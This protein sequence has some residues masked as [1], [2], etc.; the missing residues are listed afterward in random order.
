MST[1]T[2]YSTQE[3]LNESGTVPSRSLDDFVIETITSL[4]H[5]NVAKIQ[6]ITQQQIDKIEGDRDAMMKDC[7][8]RLRMNE[9]EAELCVRRAIEV[10]IDGIRQD[11]TAAICRA[12]EVTTRRVRAYLS[13]GLSDTIGKP[14]PP[15]PPL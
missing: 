3:I 10:S 2:E 1:V 9:R 7:E 4:H 6:I 11:A 12:E 14:H 8:V 13:S 15:N 5:R